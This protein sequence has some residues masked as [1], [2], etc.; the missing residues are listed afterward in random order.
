MER[1]HDDDLRFVRDV[2]PELRLIAQ[3][4]PA[5]TSTQRIERAA[6]KLKLPPA[7]FANVASM[8]RKQYPIIDVCL[9]SGLD[10]PAARAVKAMIEDD[11]ALGAACSQAVSAAQALVEK[12]PAAKAKKGGAKK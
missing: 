3:S 11:E 4:A 7:K 5:L 8:W 2:S 12:K 6:A 9:N 10:K 1:L